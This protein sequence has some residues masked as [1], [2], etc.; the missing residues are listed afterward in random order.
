MHIYDNLN[1]IPCSL[2]RHSAASSLHLD[3]GLDMV[4]M[5]PGA[6]AYTE[7]KLAF[8]DSPNLSLD[9]PDR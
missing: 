4:Y 5:V 8:W 3:L 6:V 7:A 2:L 9:I 1:G